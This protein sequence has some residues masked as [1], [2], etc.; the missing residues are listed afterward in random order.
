MFEME[1]NGLPLLWSPEAMA[2]GLP[3]SGQITR[4]KMHTVLLG[5]TDHVELNSA[6]CTGVECARAIPQIEA[7][8]DEAT[9]VVPSENHIRT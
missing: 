2:I 1:I 4:T 7:H 8:L 9:I 6:P 3:R 5:V